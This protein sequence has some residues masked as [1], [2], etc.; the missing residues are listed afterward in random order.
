VVGAAIPWLGGLISLAG[1]IVSLVFLYKI[2]PLALKIPDDKRVVHLVVSI[3]VIIVINVI[4]GSVLRVGG[5]SSPSPASLSRVDRG[6]AAPSGGMFGEIQRQAALM[7]QAGEQSFDPPSDGKVSRAQAEWV[8][9][10][11]TKAQAVVEEEVGKL[12]KL[13]KEMDEDNQPSPAD[14]AKV[15]QGMGSVVSLNNVEMETVLTADGNWAE[16]QWVKQQ[17]R[18]A[19]IQRGEGSDAIEHNY[20]LLENMDEDLRSRF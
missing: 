7:E 14:L 11:L 10:V 12:E 15:Y 6:T 19:R 18:T 8:E 20:A 2:L 9:E 13:Q 5:M 1:A 16:Y 3:I 17:L 4:V